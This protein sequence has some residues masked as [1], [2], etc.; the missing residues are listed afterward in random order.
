MKF[1]ITR[2]RDRVIESTL[3]IAGETSST[4][5]LEIF[6]TTFVIVNNNKRWW[7]VF[8]HRF[9]KRILTRVL[10]D[11]YK[12]VYNDFELFFSIIH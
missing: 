11:F 7:L 8:D 3:L 12:F 6:R 4:S 9:L 5:N 10:R 2:G 1:M